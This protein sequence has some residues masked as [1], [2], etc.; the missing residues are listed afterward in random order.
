MTRHAEPENPPGESAAPTT[1]PR[2]GMPLRPTAK[3]RRPSVVNRRSQNRGPRVVTFPKNRWRRR[4]TAFCNICASAQRLAADDQELSRGSRRADNS[5]ASGI[6]AAARAGRPDDAR[7][8]RLR[9]GHAFGRL[10][11]DDDCPAVGFAAQLFSL[12]SA[13]RGGPRPTRPSRC[14]TA[15]RTVAAPFSVDGRVGPLA[16]APPT[17]DPLG[18][19]I[20][21]F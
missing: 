16:P 19:A 9:V 11:Q 20:G 7:S 21:P 12:W 4:S 10:R 1:R 5:W 15:A 13:R 8:A 17:H 3:K 14:V 6:A 2:F 18:L